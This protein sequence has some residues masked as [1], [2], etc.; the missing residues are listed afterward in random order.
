MNENKKLKRKEKRMDKGKK[1]KF[2][3]KDYPSFPKGPQ[4]LCQDSIV[5]EEFEHSAEDCVFLTSDKICHKKTHQ[6]F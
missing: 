1:R 4:S 2:N 6:S 3:P 5:I